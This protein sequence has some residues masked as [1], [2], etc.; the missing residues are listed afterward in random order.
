MLE[1]IGKVKHQ[2]Y[3]QNAIAR[4]NEGL[5]RLGIESIWADYRASMRRGKTP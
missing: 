1:A 4:I 2:R 5:E 3:S